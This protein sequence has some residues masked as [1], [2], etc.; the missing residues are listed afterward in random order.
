MTATV[1]IAL[2]KVISYI[3]SENYFNFSLFNSTVFSK[4]SERHGFHCFPLRN[5]TVYVLLK[6][7]VRVLHFEEEQNHQVLHYKFYIQVY[8]TGSLV[9]VSSGVRVF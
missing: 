2:C 1:E 6:S 4:T 3:F 5:C 9:I 8:I 7:W